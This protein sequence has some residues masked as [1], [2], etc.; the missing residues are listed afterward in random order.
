M[1]RRGFLTGLGALL[2]T[3]AL[4]KPAAPVI[5]AVTSAVPNV[6]YWLGPDQFIAVSEDQRQDLLR[7][8]VS[9]SRGF[10]RIPPEDF[11]ES[12]VSETPN[13]VDN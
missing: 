3:S 12:P 10:E 9:I 11:F 5:E 6:T 2:A 13:P 4:V 7:V 8:G 1:N